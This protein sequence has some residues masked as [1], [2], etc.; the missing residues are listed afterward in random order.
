MDLDKGDLFWCIAS[1]DESNYRS[2]N[3]GLRKPHP[4]MVVGLEP[5]VKVSYFSGGEPDRD[6]NATTTFGPPEDPSEY[7]FESEKRAWT[8]YAKRLEEKA[9]LRRQQAEG[10]DRRAN[11]IR[12][13][14]A[15]E[16]PPEYL[17]LLEMGS[18]RERVDSVR[19]TDLE[20]IEEGEREERRPINIFPH[21][22]NPTDE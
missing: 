5:N 20:L 4:V 9:E 17:T 18:S 7:L 13:G 21:E 22:F 19:E 10:L 1:D 8:A 3:V 16:L 11:N 14:V 2:P 15:D 12:Q 6:P